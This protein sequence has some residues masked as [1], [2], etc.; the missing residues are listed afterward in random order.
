MTPPVPPTAACPPGLTPYVIRSGDTLYRIAQRFGTSVDAIRRANPGVNPNS[1]Q[2]GQL[3]CVP[4]PT[5]APAPGMCPG[6]MPYVIRAGDTLY[7]IAARF[8]TTVQAILR[9]NPGIDPNRLSIGQTICV[10]RAMAPIPR[11][12]A[13]SIVLQPVAGTTAPY[14]GGRL[15]LTIDPMGNAEITV[16]AENLPAPATMG[17]AAYSAIINVDGT[18]FAVPMVETVAGRWAGTVTRRAPAALL[19]RG[20]VN[21]YPGPVLTGWFSSC[22]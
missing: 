18:S 20:R 8:R 1:L 4:S 7:G 11:P 5:G 16:A 6:G 19:S 3:I 9:A 17:G 15:W 21:V 13:C 12:T 22:R 14:A 2:V 10:P